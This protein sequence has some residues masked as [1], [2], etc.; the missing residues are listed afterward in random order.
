M[1][2]IRG[3]MVTIIEVF[4]KFNKQGCENIEVKNSFAI[5]S[6]Q[7]HQII[8]STLEESEKKENLKEKK[9]QMHFYLLKYQ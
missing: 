4:F 2:W 3:S 1:L 7:T 6:I 9:K 5:E 8:S